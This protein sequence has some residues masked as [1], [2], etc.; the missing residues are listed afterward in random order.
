[1]G[2]GR[3]GEFCI[4]DDSQTCFFKNRVDGKVINEEWGD[5]LGSRFSDWV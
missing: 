3:K 5:R 1:M 2:L 4:R